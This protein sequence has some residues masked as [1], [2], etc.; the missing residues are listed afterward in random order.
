[1]E[2]LYSAGLDYENSYHV[3]ASILR[4]KQAHFGR[5]INQI[6]I[7][8]FVFSLQMNDKRMNQKMIT[9]KKEL[10][11][12]VPIKYLFYAFGCSSDLEMIKYIC[13]D[14]NDYG[15]IHAIRQ[16]CLQGKYHIEAIKKYLSFGV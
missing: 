3:I 16:A 8:D 2:G 4:P 6:P 7:L 12:I 15:L 10:I 5:G 9:R 13:P 11:N 1:M 14:L